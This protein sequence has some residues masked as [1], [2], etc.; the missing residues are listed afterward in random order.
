MEVTLSVF[1]PSVTL[2]TV[3]NQLLELMDGYAN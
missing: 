2:Y 1:F 3:I